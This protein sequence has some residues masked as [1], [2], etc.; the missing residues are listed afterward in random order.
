[1][2][3]HSTA[4]YVGS[5]VACDYR[6][7]EQQKRTI[8]MENLPRQAKISGEVVTRERMAGILGCSVTTV[9]RYLRSGCPGEK[10][11]KEYQ[12]N[13]ARVIRWL[14]E[15]SSRAAG[16]GD[17]ESSQAAVRRRLTLAQAELA[18]MKAAE[19][20][21]QMVAIEDVT[22]IIA[23]ELAAVRSRL[24]AAPGRVAQL[25][26]AMTDP[27]AVERAINDEIVGALSEITCG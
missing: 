23:E 11:S 21:G 7:D 25:V 9:D 17:G 27:A 4:A 19:R 14:I 20:R 18:E 22:P 8:G 1:M 5:S 26:A 12:L 24:L 10:G 3:L 15:R 16:D 13:T 6:N 2:V